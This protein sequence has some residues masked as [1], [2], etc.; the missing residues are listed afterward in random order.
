MILGDI[1]Q[2]FFSLFL[3]FFGLPVTTMKN[4]RHAG[5]CFKLI[6]PESAILASRKLPVLRDELWFLF[7]AICQSQTNIWSAITLPQYWHLKKSNQHM[8]CQYTSPILA[9]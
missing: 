2:W 5:I 9:F 3:K 6:E 7:F 8:G 4:S 1:F